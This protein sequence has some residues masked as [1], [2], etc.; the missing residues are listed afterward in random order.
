MRAALLDSLSDHDPWLTGFETGEELCFLR[1][2]LP[3]TITRKLRRGRSG[4]Q[5]E[6]DLHGRTVSKRAVSLRSSCTRR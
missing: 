4:D 6:L 3:Q 1:D 5:D 2:G